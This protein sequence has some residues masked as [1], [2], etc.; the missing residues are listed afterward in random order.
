MEKRESFCF[1]LR[2]GWVVPSSTKMEKAWGLVE[3]F[4]RTKSEMRI[5]RRRRDAESTA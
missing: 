1:N 3:G 5:R 2:T 4:E